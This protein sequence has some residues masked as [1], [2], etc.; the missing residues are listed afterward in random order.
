MRLLMFCL[1]L[2]IWGEKVL[3]AAGVFGVFA[4]VSLDPVE[5]DAI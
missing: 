2:I 3:G 4:G 5:E 1:G